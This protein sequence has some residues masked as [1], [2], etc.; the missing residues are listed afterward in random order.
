MKKYVIVAIIIIITIVCTIIIKDTFFNTKTFSPIFYQL[1]EGVNNISKSTT[2]QAENLKLTLRGFYLEGIDNEQTATLNLDDTT[3]SNILNF[4]NN[5][6]YNLLIDFSNTDGNTISE[7]IFDYFVYDNSG[8]V[9]MTSIIYE[10]KAVQKNQ[11]LKYFMEKEVYWESVYGE[12]EH[13]SNNLLEFSDYI[14]SGGTSK[15]IVNNDIDSNLILIS[16]ASRDTSKILDLSKI[17]ILILN[18]SY[19]TTAGDRIYLDNTIFE[20]ILEN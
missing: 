3:L 12:N 1:S 14:L 18:P 5:K 13:N 4:S 20:F 11:F 2:L 17:H 9:I 16:S 19:K 6:E 10:K 7:P 15:S 8:N